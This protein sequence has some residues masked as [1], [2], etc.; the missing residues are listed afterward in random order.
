MWPE[1]KSFMRPFNLGS[2][3]YGNSIHFNFDWLPNTVWKTY[4]WMEFWQRTV[5]ITFA[6]LR[7]SQILQEIILT[8]VWT[9]LQS[10]IYS[11]QPFINP[12]FLL[13]VTS[14]SLS[15][16]WLKVNLAMHSSVLPFSF[17][18]S[19]PLCFLSFLLIF[20]LYPVAISI[21]IS[22]L[23]ST[24]AQYTVDTY[25]FIYSFIYLY[26]DLWWQVDMAWWL[27]FV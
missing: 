23:R 22:N 25:S 4:N 15:L 21:S 18:H 11:F 2:K 26:T 19:F 14:L 13:D 16:W 8:T 24:R 6:K 17:I 12:S 27:C 9:P 5:F 7:S 10:W 20:S 1:C 3:K